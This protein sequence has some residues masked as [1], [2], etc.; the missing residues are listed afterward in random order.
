KTQQRTSSNVSGSRPGCKPRSL[1]SPSIENSK[2]SPSTENTRS[3]RHRDEG[4][5]KIVDGNNVGTITQ[6]TENDNELR[7]LTC[8]DNVNSDSGKVSIQ[9]PDTRTSD[10]LKSQRVELPRVDFD[11]SIQSNRFTGA[12]RRKSRNVKRFKKESAVSIV[13]NARNGDKFE[14]HRVVDSEGLTRDDAADQRNL[15]KGCLTHLIL[16]RFSSL[17]VIQLQYRTK[18][19]MCNLIHN[20]KII[21][22]LFYEMHQSG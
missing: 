14:V 19:K 20:K 9:F 5:A 16:P 8:T 22:V 12:R 4:E 7:Q 3:F 17:L 13:D 10:K 18:Y 6:P 21:G 11:E 15:R 2:P 1:T